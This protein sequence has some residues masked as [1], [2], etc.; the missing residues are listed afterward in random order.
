MDVSFGIFRWIDGW[1]VDCLTDRWMNMNEL[2]DS[3]IRHSKKPTD[4]GGC[5]D[6]DTIVAVLEI[7]QLLLLLFSFLYFEAPGE[8]PVLD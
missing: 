4:E 5:F 8:S 3:L 2:L 1:M 6:F 7:V